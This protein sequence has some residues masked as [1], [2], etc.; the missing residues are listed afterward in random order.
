MITKPSY[1]LQTTN[2]YYIPLVSSNGT[3][4]I[5]TKSNISYNINNNTLNLENLSTTNLPTCYAIPTKSTDLINRAYLNSFV[6]DYTQGWIYDDWATGTVNGS[7]DWTLD[8]NN[9]NINYMIDSEPG[10]VGILRLAGI[11]SLSFP[12]YSL[13]Q[14]G[15]SADY[16]GQEYGLFNWSNIKY[17]CYI[18][19]IYPDTNYGGF[20]FIGLGPN[21]LASNPCAYGLYRDVNETFI[22]LTINGNYVS[23]L[24]TLNI[25]DLNNKWVIFEIEITDSV[26]SFY[27][28][29]MGQP[30]RIL[31]YTQN[32]PMNTAALVRP[33]IRTTGGLID[34]D[35][36]ELRFKNMSRV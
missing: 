11:N 14:P 17:A 18:V 2:N 20:I 30:S 21:R 33:M 4:E 34:V 28:T 8:A 1:Q 25:S 24:Y 5:K 19:R 6:G 10:H 16:S 12:L 7:L 23:P 27:I 31:L 9:N 3:Q 26:L 13:S 15:V 36:F 35:Y 29:I 22:K 32:T